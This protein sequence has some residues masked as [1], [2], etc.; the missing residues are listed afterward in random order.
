MQSVARAL[1]LEKK[2][3][4]IDSHDD[5]ID[6]SAYGTVLQVQAV[7]RPPVHMKNGYDKSE[8]NFLAIGLSLEHT[9]PSL[10]KFG[11]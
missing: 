3:L 7:I 4:Q 10:E 6:A 8:N 11:D 1:Q 2:K 5:F 9:I